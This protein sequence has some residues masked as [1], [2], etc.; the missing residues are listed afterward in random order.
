VARRLRRRCHASCRT[1]LPSGP[2][3]GSDS[4]Y[5]LVAAVADQA[6]V[7]DDLIGDRLTNDDG[8]VAIARPG[9]SDEDDPTVSSSTDPLDVGATSVVLELRRSGVPVSGSGCRL[10]SIDCAGLLVIA[11]PGGPGSRSDHAPP[12]RPGPGRRRTKTSTGAQS[13]WCAAPTPPA[14]AGRRRRKPRGDQAARQGERP[15]VGTQ[16]PQTA[17]SSPVHAKRSGPV[18]VVVRRLRHHTPTERPVSQARGIMAETSTDLVP[19]T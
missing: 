18:L 6:R 7:V 9:V 11:R 16:G 5:S 14:R 10:R 8:V 1:I 17:W 12:G 15:R 3:R 13:G 19:D 4:A 2:R